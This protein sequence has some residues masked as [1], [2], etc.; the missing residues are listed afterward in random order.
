MTA[1]F[2][3]ARVRLYFGSQDAPKNKEAFDFMY[4]HKAEIEEALGTALIWNRADDNIASFIAYDMRG[5]SVGNETD[6]IQMAKFHAEW[7]K[8]FADV[9]LPVL[10]K[11]YPGVVIP[12]YSV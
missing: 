10:Q 5:I 2:D 4:A 7:G 8:K 3:C 1:N 9:L 11:K 6:W 12:K